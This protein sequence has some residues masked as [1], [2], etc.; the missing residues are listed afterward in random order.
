[1]ARV[2][3]G[4]QRIKVASGT[5]EGGL[6]GRYANALFEL[7]QDQKAVDT[8]SADLAGLRR[9][10]ETSPDLARLVRSPVF[11]AEDHAK[12]LKA[13]LEKMGANTLTTKFV[14]LLAQKRRLFVLTH[15][16]AA[17]ESLLAKSRGETEAEVTAARALSDG[18][19]A[20]LRAVLK[21]K[22]GK[23]PRLH[24]KVDPSLLGGLVVKVGS[25]MIDSSLR[26]KLDGLRAAMK[27]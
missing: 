11:S 22:L 27:G 9:A 18:E 13:I 24:A 14:L 3:A 19:V 20:E 2:R 4:P 26:T 7:A 5:A 6:A 17:F 21:S 25:R 16:I 1:L 15:V 8:V 23:E 12:A 10:L